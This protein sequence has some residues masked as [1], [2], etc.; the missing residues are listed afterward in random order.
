[1]TNPLR[2][3]AVPLNAK[4]L[5]GAEEALRYCTAGQARDGDGGGLAVNMLLGQSRW[6]TTGTSTS[7][8]A[9]RRPSSPICSH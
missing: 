4:S 7:I 9:L 1:M 3:H 8:T 6:G 5:Q 2:R